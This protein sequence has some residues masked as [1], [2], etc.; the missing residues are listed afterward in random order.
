MVDTVHIPPFLPNIITKGFYYAVRFHR[1][2]PCP[3][4]TSGFGTAYNWDHSPQP[5]LEL[6]TAGQFM[7][8]ASLFHLA[9]VLTQ[10]VFF[11]QSPPLVS[12]VAKIPVLSQIS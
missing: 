12:Y 10:P 11:M 1:T 9:P 4:S 6:R 5:S 7:S 3:S 8:R 2:L